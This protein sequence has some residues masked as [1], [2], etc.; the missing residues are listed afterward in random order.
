MRLHFSSVQLS[1]VLSSVSSSIATSASSSAA[2]SN[3]TSS[4]GVTSRAIAS[5][6]RVNSSSQGGSAGRHVTFNE[7]SLRRRNL[8]LSLSDPQETLPGID[9]GEE[10]NEEGDYQEG[11]DRENVRSYKES[12]GN[13][14]NVDT[15]SEVLELRN[16]CNSYEILM[17]SQESTIASLRAQLAEKE[18]EYAA[19]MTDMKIELEQCRLKL[20]YQNSMLSGGGSNS[21]PPSKTSGPSRQ[22]GENVA[23][24]ESSGGEDAGTGSI[25]DG[26]RLGF[27][28]E[29]IKVLRR[30]N[31]AITAEYTSVAAM[32]MRLEAEL[33]ASK[34]CVE[35][36][37]AALVK[38][39]DR[40]RRHSG[41]QQV[42][43]HGG[44]KADT[45]DSLDT[46]VL[47]PPSPSVE[48]RSPPPPLPHH[49]KAR[50]SPTASTVSTEANNGIDGLL[51]E[52]IATK[53]QLA[54]LATDHDMERMKMFQL[55]RK[56]QW[57]AERI[58]ALEVSS[59]MSS[60]RD[61][62]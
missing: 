36:L 34:E 53:L 18:Q 58:A 33:R 19:Q 62:R 30:N 61:Q 13:K 28:E 57:Y 41:E 39:E 1:P 52:L 8:S 9:D 45:A 26:T 60:S 20:A 29:E 51:N 16:K 11:D 4:T 15:S 27:L 22:Y 24:R 40:D 55:T 5:K 23:S 2:L 37:R 17:S 6:S 43:Q 50:H 12:N 48:P 54:T 44:S 25:S 49:N 21:S 47:T 59:A 56:L 32:T 10:G 35:N 38:Y 42:S 7:E 31:A 14:I 46:V 3:T